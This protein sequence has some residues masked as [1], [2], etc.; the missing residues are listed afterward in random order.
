[1]SANQLP[2][3]LQI[4]ISIKYIQ[5]SIW[6]RI[7]ISDR[8]TL[9]DLHGVIQAVFSW[10]DYHL[11]EF[12]I[13]HITYGDPA[14]DEFGDHP[15]LDETEYELNSFGLTKGSR[16]NY[17]YDFGD[18]WEHSLVVEEM[19]PLE[20]RTK[21]PR[22]IGG[23]RACPPEDVGGI[24]GYEEFVNILKDPQH[25]EYDRYLVWVGGT[26]EP[27]DFDLTLAN[28][29]LG[30]FLQKKLEW[31]PRP[32]YSLEGECDWSDPQITLSSWMDQ[33]GPED[34]ESMH[35]LPLRRDAVSLVTY[36]KEHKVKGT[37]STGNL[38]QK[39]VQDI[40]ALLVTPPVMKY[41]F[42]T[43]TIE[44]K[45]EDDI[46]SIYDIHL[47]VYLADLIDGCRGRLWTTTDKGE[48]F[49]ISSS[50]EQLFILF[51]AWWFKGNWS[52]FR[53]RGQVKDGFEIRF[54][55]IA[56]NALLELSCEIPVNYSIFVKR[57]LELS[58]VTLRAQDMESGFSQLENQFGMDIIDPLESFAVLSTE[59][60]EKRHQFDFAKIETVRLTEM[61]KKILHSLK[62]NP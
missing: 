13:N 16:F 49:L 22:C 47:F 8:M 35:Q 32:E 17:V 3:L 27:N 51:T 37:N 20:K 39:A 10:Q 33:N 54:L 62:T 60:K 28:D 46:Q 7:M 55:D 56:L 41:E 52:D 9:Q 6:R 42:Q 31:Y 40:A 21:L 26:F 36:I 59:R 45:N 23:K 38:S 4:K 30:Q 43:L 29:R 61:G 53:V 57:I 15:V 24:G 58:G 12:E 19:I 44:Y 1:M 18:N 5:P 50:E 14:N 25:D 2:N 11:H 34:R 48:K